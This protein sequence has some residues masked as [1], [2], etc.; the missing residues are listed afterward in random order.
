[1]TEQIVGQIDPPDR[2]D[3]VR[4]I[5]A[6][7][8]D[9]LLAEMFNGA[10]LDTQEFPPLEYAVP[11][12]IPEGFGLL[13][14]PPK[15]GKSWLVCGIGLACAAGGLALGRISVDKRP[16]L[17]LALEDGQRRLQSRCRRIMHGPTPDLFTRIPG[18]IHFITKAKPAAIIPMITEFLERHRDDN[19]PLVILDTLGKARPPRPAG[20]DLYAW[21]Y[22]IGTQLKDTIDTAPGSTLLVVHHT[23]KA[24]SPDFVDSV[25]GSQGVAGSADFVLALSRKRH[26]DEA[27][28]SVT[29]RDVIEAEYALNASDGLWQLDGSTLTAASETAEHRRLSDTRSDRSMEIFSIVATSPTPLSPTEVSEKLGIDNDTAGRYLRRLAQNGFIKRAGRGLYESVSEVSEEPK[30]QHSDTPDT[31]DTDLEEAP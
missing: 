30:E 20:A 15:A 25:S 27:L 2:S 16:V 19:P 1:M 28:L 11:G 18:G 14:S 17:Y 31:S 7:E 21:D 8:R 6:D 3:E 13:V 26:S 24:E 10:W 23:R 5:Y 22:A 29:G 9:D 12:I 4:E